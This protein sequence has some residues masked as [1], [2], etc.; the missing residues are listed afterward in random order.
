MTPDLVDVDVSLLLLRYGRD[1]VVRALA[2]HLD[3]TRDQ[4]EDQIRLHERRP[5]TTRRARPKPDLAEL[6]ASESDRRP[7]IASQ[8]KSLAE[9]L[10]VGLFSPT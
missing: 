8:L 4:I 1:K 10:R 3:L 9:A 6:T 7:E 5:S 2:R